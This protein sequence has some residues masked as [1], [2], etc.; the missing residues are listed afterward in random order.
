ML[1]G[2]RNSIILT[3]NSVMEKMSYKSST[4]V[5]V[6]NKIWKCLLKKKW[7]CETN[8]QLRLAGVYMCL[9]HL[10]LMMMSYSKFEVNRSTNVEVVCDTSFHVPKMPLSTI[11]LSSRAHNSGRLG[12]LNMKFVSCTSTTHDDFIV[13]VWSQSLD[14]CRSSLRHKLSCCK[15]ASVHYIA[16]FKGT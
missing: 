12:P 15:N 6:K 5:Q 4:H 13:Q 9:A 16:K 2:N 10:R 3:T 7:H 1:F 14:K 8:N 11:L